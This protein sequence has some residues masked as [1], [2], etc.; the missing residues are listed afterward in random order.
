LPAEAVRWTG[1]DFDLDESL[2][3]VADLAADVLDRGM[4]RA[5]DGVALWQDMGQAGLLSLAL[6]DWLGG[7]GLGVL[8]TA[9]L[10]T[11]VGRQAAPVP[12]LG[13]LMLGVLPVVRWGDCDLQQ[14]VLAGIAKGDT[15]LT[16]AVRER[17][18][19][20][21]AEPTATAYLSGGTGTVSGIKIGVLHAE[22]AR[23]ILVPASLASGGTAVVLIDPT[24]AGVSL[25]P[26]P[27]AAEQPEYTLRLDQAPVGHVLGDG[28]EPVVDDLYQLGLA[29]ACC[30]GDGA[31]SAALALTTA[32]LRSREQFG[33]P[34]AAFQAVAQQI[35]DAYIAARTVHL[36]AISAC[37]RLETAREAGSDPEVAAYWLAEHAPRALRVCH[38]L[39]GG[40]GMDISYPLHRFSLLVKDLVRFTG[41]ADYCLDRLGGRVAVAAAA[42]AA[43]ATAAVSAS[44]SAAASGTASAAAWETDPAAA[45]ETASAVTSA[46]DSDTT[47]AA[48]AGPSAPISAGG[49]DDGAAG[50]AADCAESAGT[51][52]TAGKQGTRHV[53]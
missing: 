13:T 21:P 41:G 2:Q 9:I 12:A 29:G 27:S 19:P 17:S 46:A 31:L 34:L 20:M 48:P 40:I 36:A 37:W 18:D 4:P 43:A 51:G 30:L 42:S 10:L 22:A 33:R 6:P 1:L 14:A 45:S 53:P 50:D 49:L 44:R 23:W 52:V 8:G 35:A 15:V 38:H 24:A 5:A 16:A 39:H 47:T 32:H 7:D 28:S 11:E 25:R 26:T 3:A